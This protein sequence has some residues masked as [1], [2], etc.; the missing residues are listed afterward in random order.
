MK[1][2]LLGLSLFAAAFAQAADRPDE[3]YDRDVQRL[4][5]TEFFAFGGTG[6]AGSTSEGEAAFGRIVGKKEAIRHLWAAFEHGSDYSRCYALVALRESSPELY[7]RAMA[8]FRQHPPSRIK[9][10]K[11]CIVEEEE[12]GAVL[13]AI[14]AGRYADHFKKYEL[15]NG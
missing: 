14:E 9:T 5:H 4:I 2:L 6:F 1:S 12:A 3:Y 15:K 10:M 11:G 13:D 8:W 7:R